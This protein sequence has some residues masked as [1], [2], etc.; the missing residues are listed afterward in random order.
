MRCGLVS[1]DQGLSM[2]KPLASATAFSTREKYS[3]RAPAQGPMAPCERERSGLGTTR[4]GSTSKRVP[5]PLHDGHAPKGELNE[6]LLGA[7]S[8]SEI[9]QC[10]HARCWEKVST[11]SPSWRPRIPRSAP[12]AIPSSAASAALAAAGLRRPPW[13]FG[14]LAGV[15][16]GVRHEQDLGDPLAE[17]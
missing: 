13:S 16:L 3:V 8:S 14:P 5:S 4:S 9:P 17:A 1:L 6:K 10:T 7:S 11:C 12:S 2:L 15:R